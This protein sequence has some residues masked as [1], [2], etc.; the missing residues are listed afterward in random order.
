ML[1]DV[2]IS[3][4]GDP[5]KGYSKRKDVIG[6]KQYMIIIPD[7]PTAEIGRYFN[8]VADIINIFRTQGKRVFIHCHAGISR[9]V[10]LL[11]AYYLKYKNGNLEESLKY[12]K[13]KRPY[14]RPNDGFLVQL[15]SFEKWLTDKNENP[16]DI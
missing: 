8:K 13:N 1:V 16:I 3:V 5:P 9:S 11:T 12:I 15:I 4:Y 6:V 2:V 10:S 14:I 7:S